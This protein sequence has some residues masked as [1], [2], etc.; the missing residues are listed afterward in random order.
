MLPEVFGTWRRR[1]GMEILPIPNRRGFRSCGLSLLRGW[2]E[3]VRK[4]ASR[5]GTNARFGENVWKLKLRRRF[6]AISFRN[7]RKFGGCY[8][9][10]RR[11][12]WLVSFLRSGVE[13]NGGDVVGDGEWFSG[14]ECAECRTRETK[15]VTVIGVSRREVV[16]G[17]NCVFHETAALLAPPYRF[18]V[19][20]L[21]HRASHF[22]SSYIYLILY[23]Y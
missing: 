14:G 16:A 22:F 3:P 19:I 21:G 7:F 18:L 1:R 4:L 6:P 8:G 13:E 12:W 5:R 9:G 20:E 15:R 2:E 17:I 23:S 11:R 10:R